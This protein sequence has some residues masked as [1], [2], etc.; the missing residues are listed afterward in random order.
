M[1]SFFLNISKKTDSLNEAVGRA[2]S[3][4]TLVL[5]AV[6]C[7]DV[8]ARKV[9]N[10]S[11]VWFMDLEWHLFSLIFLLASGYAL[12][13][14]RHVRVDLFYDNYTKKDKALTDFVGSLL[15]LI[16]WCIIVIAYALSYAM[17]AFQLR[18]GASEPGG[19]PARYAIKFAIVLGIFLLLLQAFSMLIKAALI[20]FG[21][22][23]NGASK[24]EQEEES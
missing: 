17:D 10:F 16:P 23:K 13:H 18:E 7:F 14:D 8:V 9:F 2:S 4:L 19:L 24:V 15:F 22:N 6:V 11:R 5:L 12:L 1:S 3:W 21:K 20:L